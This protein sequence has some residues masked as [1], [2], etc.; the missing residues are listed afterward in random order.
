M[1]AHIYA[2]P[3]DKNFCHGHG[4]FCVFDCLA[5]TSNTHDLNQ[6]GFKHENIFIRILSHFGSSAEELPTAEGLQA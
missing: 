6:I 3:F 4:H 5:W 2:H 1:L